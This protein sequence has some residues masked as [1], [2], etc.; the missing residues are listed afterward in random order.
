VIRV[1]SKLKLALIIKW[2]VSLAVEFYKRLYSDTCVSA[3]S[4]KRARAPSGIG[5]P[6]P[7]PFDMR[8]LAATT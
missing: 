4:F 8:V 2:L 5:G 1:S 7:C 6:S 3:T